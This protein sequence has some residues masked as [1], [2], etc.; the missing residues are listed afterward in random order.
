ME[1]SLNEGI[2]AISVFFNDASRQ[3]FN[4]N[5]RVNEIDYHNVR[6]YSDLSNIL[7]QHFPKIAEIV[8]KK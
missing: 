4:K 2:M 7:N 8:A 6:P 1:E 5:M 3:L